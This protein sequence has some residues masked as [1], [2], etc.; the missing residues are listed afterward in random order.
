M[1]SSLVCLIGLEAIVSTIPVVPSP[2]EKE[3]GICHFSFSKT[4]SRHTASFMKYPEPI[5]TSTPLLL[6]FQV[7]YLNNRWLGESITLKLIW[8]RTTAL[9]LARWKD[10]EVYWTDDD[11]YASPRSTKGRLYVPFELLANGN[12]SAPIVDRLTSCPST[13]RLSS[14]SPLSP[15]W[16][17]KA[18]TSGVVGFYHRTEIL[19]YLGKVTEPNFKSKPWT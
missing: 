10:P 14:S 9:I 19:R 13:V 12:V 7:V 2:F 6:L 8:S 16:T 11:S 1:V 4:S 18:M 15:Q 17:L 3:K 5:I